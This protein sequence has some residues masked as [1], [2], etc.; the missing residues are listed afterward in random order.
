MRLTSFVMRPMF[1]RQTLK[2]MRDF[3]RFAEGE[4][5]AE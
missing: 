2:V 3:K 5:L 4:G 1:K